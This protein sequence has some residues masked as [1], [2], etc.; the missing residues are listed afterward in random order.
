[1]KMGRWTKK[2]VVFK[3]QWNVQR[4]IAFKLTYFHTTR[5][6]NVFFFI[7]AGGRKTNTYY[8][9]IVY[10]YIRY[11][12]LSIRPAKYISSF[13]SYGWTGIAFIVLSFCCCCCCCFCFIA[14][15][16]IEY[17]FSYQNKY[18][19]LFGPL[20]LDWYWIVVW[21]LLVPVCTCVCLH[22]SCCLM[23]ES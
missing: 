23:Q 22:C 3:G 11:N 15:M 8:I 17:N 20:R 16:R 13:I 7:A 14:V 1:M 10:I 21:I 19:F 12:I 5:K 4:K 9:R 6:R 2:K 18:K